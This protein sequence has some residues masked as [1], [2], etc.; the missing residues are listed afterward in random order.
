MIQFGQLSQVENSMLQEETSLNKQPALQLAKNLRFLLETRG[1]N[2]G[3]LAESLGISKM[4]ISRL[5]SGT[6]TDP[7]ISTVK[8]IADHFSV[9]V[10]SLIYGD[11]KTLNTHSI[12]NTPLILPT[13]DWE[14]AKN[15]RTIEDLDLKTWENWQPVSLGNQKISKNSFTLKSL[16]SMYPR[17]QYG[18]IFVIDPEAKPEDGDIV[19]VKVKESGEITLKEISIDPPHYLLNSI[20]KNSS[21]VVYET[22][23]FEISG[24]NILTLLFKRKE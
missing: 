23:R 10:D 24:V 14:T 4:A 6:T 2:A 18:T 17:F 21:Q 9:P 1:T 15:I 8:L 7:R 12:G 11:Q 20:T 16:P 5:L 13:L 22:D 19:L 3:Q